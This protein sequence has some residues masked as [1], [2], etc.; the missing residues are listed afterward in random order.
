MEQR[1]EKLDIRPDHWNIVRDILRRCLPAGTTVRIFGSRAR[2]TARPY[3]DLDIAI[4]G[5]HPLGFDLIGQIAEAFSDSD[6]PYKVDIVDLAAVDPGFAA[7]VEAQGIL[8]PPDL[9]NS[10]PTR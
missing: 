10:V 3:S 9:P 8:L 7:I 6:L 2:R 5:P 4:K 1:E